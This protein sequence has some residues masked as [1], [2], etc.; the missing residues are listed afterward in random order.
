[1]T[2]AVAAVTWGR[3]PCTCRDRLRACRNR[4]GRSLPA[5][6]PGEERGGGDR[7]IYCPIAWLPP[8]YDPGPG[9]PARCVTAVTKLAATWLGVTGRDGPCPR[10]GLPVVTDP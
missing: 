8:L 5:E 4:R 2:G 6:S 7:V 9:P 1:M 10:T 3:D